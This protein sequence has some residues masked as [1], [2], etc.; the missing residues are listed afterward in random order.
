MVIK[1][2]KTGVPGLDK[3]MKGGVREN[4]S[5]LISGGPGT[6]KTMF[7]MQFLLQGAKEGEPGLCVLYDTEIEDFL[8]YADELGIP[9]RKYVKE[10]KIHMLKQPIIVRKVSSLAAPLEMMRKKKI[11]RVLLDSLTMFAYMHVRDDREYRS[12][13]VTFLEHMKKVTLFS[14][15]EASGGNL[16][17]VNFKPEDFLFDGVIFLTKV[18][19]EASF[20]RV[21]HVSKMRGQDHLLDVLPFQIGKG[22]VKVYTGQLPFALM[23]GKKK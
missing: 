15:V 2:L 14:T 19:R 5:V 20:E 22:G 3:V 4:S 21:I 8:N 10:K 13:I 1:K 23:E 7:G 6:G 17:E 11:K 12:E 9:L 18:R 16:D